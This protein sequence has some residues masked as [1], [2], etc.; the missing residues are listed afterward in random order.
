MR[1]FPIISSKSLMVLWISLKMNIKNLQSNCTSQSS[2]TL[3]NLWRNE[4]S[5][6]TNTSTWRLLG[7]GR[8]IFFINMCQCSRRKHAQ[9]PY[10]YRAGPS[11]NKQLKGKDGTDWEKWSKWWFFHR[12]SVRSRKTLLHECYITFSFRFRKLLDHISRSVKFSIC[13]QLRRFNSK[14]AT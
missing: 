14:R 5:V 8:S 3:S 6:F 9:K 13:S 12:S 11:F 4:N 2:P 10:G 7:K 1:M